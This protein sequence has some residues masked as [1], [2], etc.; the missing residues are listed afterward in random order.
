[1]IHVT[2]LLVLVTGTLVTHRAM[3]GETVRWKQPLIM[4]MGFLLTV[5]ALIAVALSRVCK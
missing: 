5:L 1:M 4:T 3:L 2:L